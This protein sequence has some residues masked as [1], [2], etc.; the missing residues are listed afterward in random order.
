MLGNISGEN[1]DKFIYK[2]SRIGKNK[3]LTTPKPLIEPYDPLM[4]DDD[5]FMKVCHS[6]RRMITMYTE[7]DTKPFGGFPPKILTDN[8]IKEF[9][10]SF[11]NH[12]VCPRPYRSY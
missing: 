2:Y 5:T 1:F 12:R 9:M 8:H 3:S 10:R 6:V 4:I 11:K 7:L